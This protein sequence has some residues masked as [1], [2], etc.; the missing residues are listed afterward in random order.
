MEVSGVSCDAIERRPYANAMEWGLL[1]VTGPAAMQLAHKD[2]VSL[3]SFGF[4]FFSSVHPFVMDFEDFGADFLY[5]HF[6]EFLG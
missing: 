1:P 6:S 2:F 5:V 4:F 3:R